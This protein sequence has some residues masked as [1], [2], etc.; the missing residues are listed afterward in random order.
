M[1]TNIHIR[2]SRPTDAAELRRLAALD[3]ATVPHGDLLIAE[4]DGRLVAAYSPDDSR[5]I[6]DPF[7]HTAVVVDMLRLRS[8]AASPQAQRQVRTRALPTLRAA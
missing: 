8:R 4:E 7:R 5:A 2:D 3:S 6:A 1:N